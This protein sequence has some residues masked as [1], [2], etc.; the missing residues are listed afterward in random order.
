MAIK[1]QI[2]LSLSPVKLIM[3]WLDLT[4]LRAEREDVIINILCW[5]DELQFAPL[6]SCLG[7]HRG[8]GMVGLTQL[9]SKG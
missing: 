9:A 6:T 4:G 5:E 3:F 1:E 8:N 7:W 2:G